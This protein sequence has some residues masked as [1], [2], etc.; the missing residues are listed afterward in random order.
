MTTSSAP[1]ADATVFACARARALP[2]VPILTAPPRPFVRRSRRPCHFV[3]RSRR[4]PR[5]RGLEAEPRVLAAAGAAHVIP[6]AEPGHGGAVSGG[7]TGDAL[8]YEVDQPTHI[9]GVRSRRRGADG[10]D[11]VTLGGLRR[12]GVEVPEHLHVVA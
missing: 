10:C 12:L 4:H 1:S 2:R 6:G 3:R 11:A 9:G 5:N 8:E 7:R